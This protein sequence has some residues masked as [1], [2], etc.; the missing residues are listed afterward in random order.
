[1]FGNTNENKNEHSILNMSN[2][3]TNS[4][5]F[6]ALLRIIDI[7]SFYNWYSLRAKLNSHYEAWSYKK[8]SKKD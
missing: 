4:I 6:V 5:G 8:I 3:K 1:M 2:M 7:D